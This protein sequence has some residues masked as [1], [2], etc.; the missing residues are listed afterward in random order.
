MIL[1]KLQISPE[2][3]IPIAMALIVVGLSMTVI[4]TGWSRISPSAPHADTDWNDFIRG[5]IFGI[6][7]VLEIAGVAIATRAAAAKRRNAL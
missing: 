1:R 5:F 7:I 4:G 6:A 2:K 3:M